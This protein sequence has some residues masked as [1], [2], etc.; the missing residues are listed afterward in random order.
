VHPGEAAS[1]AEVEPGRLIA[2]STWFLRTFGLP[3]A[4]G[5]FGAWD[6]L[7]R[8]WDLLTAGLVG[9][10]VGG[11]LLIWMQVI[12]WWSYHYMLLLVPVGLLAARGIESLWDAMSAAVSPHQRRGAAAVALL[13]LS[14][15]ALP[16]V[17]PAVRAVA[18]IARSRPLPL[19]S[20]SVRAYQ[21]QRSQE[22]GDAL[23]A[24]AFLREPASHDGPIYALAN[25]VHYHL[26]GRQPA[27]PLLA[28]WFHPTAELWERL[29]T[30]LARAAP[31]YVLVDDG[32]LDAMV[33]YNPDLRTEVKGLR[34]ALG[35]QY[36]ELQQLPDGTWYVRRDLETE[37]G[38]S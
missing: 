35:A 24:T 4:L 37:T 13:G 31:P 30:G 12:S 1:E 34:R 2:S 23:E 9:W 14:V 16:L 25:P 6:R 17:E 38:S 22:Y 15:L 27:V 7:R 20:E 32:A 5:M 11:A 28:P 19:D 3:L 21:A 8:G 18:D 33:G 10:L 36:R 26:A 29:V